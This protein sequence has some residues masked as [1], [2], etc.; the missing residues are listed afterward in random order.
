MGVELTLLHALYIL[1]LLT[2]ITFFIL[3]K[4]TTII[5][6]VFIFLLALTATSSI[7]LA[8]SGI[9]QSFIYAITELLPT[10]GI[11]LLLFLVYF[12][13]R[14]FA[15]KTYLVKNVATGE[16]FR[17]DKQDFKQYKREFKAKEKEVR[18]ISDLQ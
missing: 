16:T 4:D 1:C 7:P 3:R 8:I 14:E 12:L 11:S 9:F 2:I 10:L 5:C 18:K 17:V 6:I 13:L 15:F